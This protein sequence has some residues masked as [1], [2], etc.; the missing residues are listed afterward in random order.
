VRSAEGEPAELHRIEKV[1]VA[2]KVSIHVSQIQLT[3]RRLGEINVRYA[4]GEGM[5]RGTPAL[6]VFTEDDEQGGKLTIRARD[7]D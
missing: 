1:V 5:L 3:Q 6:A 7:A 4:Y 2:G